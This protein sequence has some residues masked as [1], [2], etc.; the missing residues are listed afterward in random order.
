MKSKIE[1]LHCPCGCELGAHHR[2]ELLY[3]HFKADGFEVIGMVNC[4]T[5]NT[6]LVVRTDK[7]HDDKVGKYMEQLMQVM[8]FKFRAVYI[9]GDWCL[10]VSRNDGVIYT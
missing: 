9:A 4:S 5:T 6:E 8:G 2:V 10:D 3:E 7:L 1:D